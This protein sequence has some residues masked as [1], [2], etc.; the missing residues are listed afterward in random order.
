LAWV[1]P[2]TPEE[3]PGAPIPPQLLSADVLGSTAVSS[4]HPYAASATAIVSA[5]KKNAFV[6]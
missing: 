6:M 3:S 4:W 1:K 2:R 5:A